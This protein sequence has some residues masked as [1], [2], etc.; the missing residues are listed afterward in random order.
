MELY[1]VY[2]GVR[3]EESWVALLGVYLLVMFFALAVSFVMWLLQ[4]IGIYKMAKTAG[5]NNAWLAFIPIGCLYVLGKI[6]EVPTENKK[7]LRYGLIL[8]LLNVGLLVVYIALFFAAIVVG[9]T[10]ELGGDLTGIYFE[11]TL[12]MLIAIAELIV[13]PL[14]IVISVFT[15]I[16]LYRIYKL[17]DPNNAVVYLVLSIL[18]N[19]LQPI[20]LFVLRNKPLHGYAFGQIPPVGTPGYNPAYGQQTYSPYGQNVYMP[21]VPQQTKAEEQEVV[22][23]DTSA[24]E[25]KTEE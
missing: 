8:P 21:P 18:I 14:A 25:N 22:T 2:G 1:D 12:V 24:E 23:E 5:I 15:Y 10:S 3:F 17:F 19:I 4:S 16:A 9:F 13:V 7:P 20:F 11:N 6:A